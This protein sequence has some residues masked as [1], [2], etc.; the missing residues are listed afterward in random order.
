M[1]RKD[2]DIPASAKFRKNEDGE[3]VMV[4]EN[5]PDLDDPRVGRTLARVYAYLLRRGREADNGEESGNGET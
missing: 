5:P 4:E 3:Y 1:T 2:A